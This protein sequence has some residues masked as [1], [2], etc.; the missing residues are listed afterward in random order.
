MFIGL[1]ALDWKVQMYEWRGLLDSSARGAR[2][3]SSLMFPFPTLFVDLTFRFRFRHVFAET[4]NSLNIC[5]QKCL[6]HLLS[7]QYKYCGKRQQLITDYLFVSFHLKSNQLFV[8][9][10]FLST[11]DVT[12]NLI[13]SIMPP[14][15]GSHKS[16]RQYLSSNIVFKI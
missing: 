13:E 4:K 12:I 16:S 10:K 2:I 11:L 3:R 15:E 14:V 6:I 8:E 1:E 5:W 9:E 7:Y